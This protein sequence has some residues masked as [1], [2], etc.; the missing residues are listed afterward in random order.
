VFLTVKYLWWAALPF[1]LP[2]HFFLNRRVKRVIAHGARPF[3]RF[4][5]KGRIGLG[6]SARFAGIFEEWLLQER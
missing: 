3:T 4:L 5:H 6:G 2:A 1:A